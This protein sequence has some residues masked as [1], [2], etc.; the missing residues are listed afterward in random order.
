MLPDTAPVPAT[1]GCSKSPWFD[2]NDGEL[3]S[4]PLLVRLLQT[5]FLLLGLLFGVIGTILRGGGRV[6]GWVVWPLVK[7]GMV[8]TT[9]AT[10]YVALRDD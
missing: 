10:L 4:K 7:V 1:V 3:M 2:S 5:P 8:V 6:F 9:L